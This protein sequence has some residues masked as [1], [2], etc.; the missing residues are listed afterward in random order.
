M[1]YRYLILAGMMSLFTNCSAISDLVEEITSADCDEFLLNESDTALSEACREVADYLESDTDSLAGLTGDGLSQLMPLGDLSES[2][3]AVMQLTDATGT[4]LTDITTEDV[5]VELSTDGGETFSEIEGATVESMGD[6]EATQS[7]LV[8]LVD[9]SAS[10]LDDDIDD[11]VS[12]LTVFYENLGIGYESA[13]MK[14]STDVDVIEDF[15]TDTDALLA[16]VQDTS[17]LREYTSLNDAI[18]DAADRLGARTLPLRI[19]VLF[20]DGVDNDSTYSQAQAITHAQENNVAVCVVGVSFADVTTLQTIAEETGCFFVY[21]TLF[22]DLSTAFNTFVDQFN[23]LYQIDLPEDFSA[24]EGTLRVTVDNGVD[25]V[26][27]F[28]GEF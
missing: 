25:A 20:T 16:A 10:I 18:Y 21:K 24:T 7:S 4:P 3:V 22:S 13:V 27:T 17:Y 23:G 5:T 12:G 6:V 2:G 8:T 15:T 1:Q 19:V 14:F 26:R 11:V 28:T 9:Y